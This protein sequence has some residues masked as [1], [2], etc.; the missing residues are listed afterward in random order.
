K[1]P[2]ITHSGYVGMGPMCMRP[3]DITV[4]FMMARLLCVIRGCGGGSFQ[5]IGEC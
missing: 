3:G 4:V 1:R 5:F 2:F